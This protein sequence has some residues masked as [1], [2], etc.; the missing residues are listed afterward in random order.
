MT[1]THDVVLICNDGS[2]R[3]FRVYG[4]PMPNAGETITLPVD[5]RLIRARVN[6]KCSVSLQ[7][8]EMVQSVDH[9]DAAEIE[10]LVV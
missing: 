8:P 9:A 5:G 10:E 4:R 3:N 2:L 1:H 6:G 7:K